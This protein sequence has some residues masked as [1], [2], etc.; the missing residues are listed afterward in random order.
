MNSGK[1]E[2]RDRDGEDETALGTMKRLWGKL[3]SRKEKWLTLF[4]ILIFFSSKIAE[5]WKR[6]RKVRMKREDS[7]QEERFP[8]FLFQW[9]SPF[10]EGSIKGGTKRSGG[11]KR[12]GRGS[13]TVQEWWVELFV[14]FQVV[15]G[16][17][18]EINDEKNEMT[19][20][21]EDLA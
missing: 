15:F 20:E 12:G 11:M 10:K 17:R 9:Q 14:L 7:G 13:N 5:L 2:C 4:P 18:I 19:S 8:S 3:N 21:N 1:K 6:W 16:N